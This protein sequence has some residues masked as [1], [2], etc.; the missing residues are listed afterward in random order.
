MRP[1]LLIALAWMLMAVA[2]ISP[3]HAQ[4]MSSGLAGTCSSDYTVDSQIERLEQQ[5]QALMATAGGTEAGQKMI[6]Q[7]GMLK[8]MQ[9]GNGFV[10][11]TAK[12]INETISDA[13]ERLYKG[14]A[15]GGYASLV[16]SVLVLY[17]L[18]FAAMFTLGMVQTPLNEMLVRVVKMLVV[19]SVVGPAGWEF[20]NEYV[21]TLFTSGRDYIIGQMLQTMA[22]YT[23]GS[24]G[25]P[26]DMGNA[27]VPVFTPIDMLFA[28]IIQPSTLMMLEAAINTPPYGIIYVII[29]VVGGLFLIGAVARALWVYLVSVLAISFLFGLAPLFV[30][31]MLFERTKGM[32]TAWI[33]QIVNFTLQPIL[34]FTFITFFVVLLDYSV[35]NM[36][37]FEACFGE[38][39]SVVEAQGAGSTSFGLQFKVGDDVLVATC[40]AGGCRCVPEQGGAEV[41]CPDIEGGFPLN[42]MDVLSFLLL[43]YVAFQFYNNVVDIANDISG[44]FV[45]LDAATSS[46][47]RELMDKAGAGIQGATVQAL[48]GNPSGAL[49]EMGLGGLDQFFKR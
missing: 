13:A 29:L 32:F 5:G 36:L 7:A 48:K 33:S 17:V 12:Q 11:K 43:C 4:V 49:Q 41:P 26:V 22:A 19:A 14:I 38:L 2:G 47:V 20:F 18:I 3:A 37:K 30:V 44:A 34:M 8:E 16:A 31:A 1:V 40:E 15:T 10:S 25:A 6:D 27:D 23:G 35:K 28:Q 21:V 9:A 24:V 42:L 39:F 45:N 46:P